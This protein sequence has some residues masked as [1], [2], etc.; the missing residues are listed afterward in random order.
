MGSD[1]EDSF[2]ESIE[3]TYITEPEVLS[4]K[5]AIIKD[6]LDSM[7]HII[8]NENASINQWNEESKQ[9]PIITA[10]IISSLNASDLKNAHEKK[11]AILVKKAELVKELKRLI[12]RNLLKIKIIIL[13][14]ML[15]LIIELHH[16]QLI[17]NQIP[18]VLNGLNR[19]VKK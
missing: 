16:P 7:I 11:V 17:I 2:N 13:V 19:L 5:K 8:T 1:N 18:M 3:Y 4:S 14:T 10:I 9:P 12:R 15:M 6:V